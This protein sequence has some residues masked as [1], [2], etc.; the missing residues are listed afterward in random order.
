M[1]PVT[2]P[3]RVRRFHW[4]LMTLSGRSAVTERQPGRVV[5]K[6]WTSR[7]GR[8]WALPRRYTAPDVSRREGCYGTVM[9]VPSPVAV[10]VNV[11]VV[12][13]VYV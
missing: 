13:D 6:V 11:P 8:A 9:V 3:Y 1:F 5:V 4:D 12:A 10:M 7:R 2:W